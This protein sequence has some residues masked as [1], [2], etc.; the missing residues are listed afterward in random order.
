MI[1][2][3][4]V[5]DDMTY[6]TVKYSDKSPIYCEDGEYRVRP[7][8]VVVNKDT[9]V[10]ELTTTS[11]PT[12]IYQAQHLDIMLLALLRGDEVAPAA[13]VAEDVVAH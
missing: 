7:G 8:Y 13:G 5:N 6:Y 4:K 11:L 3:S 12:A 1:D 2:L 9:D 10:V